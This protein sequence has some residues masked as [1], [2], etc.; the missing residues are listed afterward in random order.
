MLRCLWIFINPLSGRSTGGYVFLLRSIASF[1][2]HYV[3]KRSEAYKR[4]HK[5]RGKNLIFI[6]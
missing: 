5:K 3:E 4:G 1:L 6:I 2:L